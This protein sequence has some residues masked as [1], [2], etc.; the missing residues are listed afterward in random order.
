MVN[1]GFNDILMIKLFL[2]LCSNYKGNENK[3][4]ELYIFR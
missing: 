3:E 2:I 1:Y 4:N